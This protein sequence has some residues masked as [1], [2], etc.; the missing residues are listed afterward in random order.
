MWGDLMDEEQYPQAE[1]CELEPQNRSRSPA[2]ASTGPEKL[3]WPY[4]TARNPTRHRQSGTSIR[5]YKTWREKRARPFHPG[6]PNTLKTLA[7]ISHRKFKKA[8]GFL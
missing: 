8:C 4:P 5:L 2:P 1:V 3:Q 7:R 6:Y